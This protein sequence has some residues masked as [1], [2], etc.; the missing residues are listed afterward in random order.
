A[1]KEGPIVVTNTENGDT[2]SGGTFIFRVPKPLITNI[3][4]P[5]P[6]GGTATIT[7]LNALGFARITIG[8]VAVPI[9][10]SVPN[11]NGTT[12][13]TVQLPPTIQLATV[14]CPNGGSAPLPTAFDVVYT[15]ATTGCTDT[16]PKGITISPAAAPLL[17]AN[18]GAFQPFAATFSAGSPG[19]PVIP[20]STTPSGAQTVQIVNNGTTP[21]DITA[22]TTTNGAGTGCANFAV[23]APPVPPTISLNQCE[24]LPII[25]TYNG[26]IPTPPA[27]TATDT[28]T[29]TIT[30][31]AGNKTFL[32]VG[33]TR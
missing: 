23:S 32:L 7:V 27:T 28:C 26:T 1:D 8:G 31:N 20:P 21:L 24:S 13:F 29:L 2:A 14:S 18:P 16:A 3:S 30:T 10:A 4:N 11:A 19:P 6:A 17:F 15:S 25:V 9:T 22:I 33:S 12:T 5:N